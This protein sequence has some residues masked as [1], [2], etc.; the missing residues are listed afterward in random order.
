MSDA[1]HETHRWGE[2]RGVPFCRDCKVEGYEDEPGAF[3]ECPGP[4]P[5]GGVACGHK[6]ESLDD[7]GH[8]H[9]C[10]IG[11]HPASMHFCDE[12]ERWFG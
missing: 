4:P 10:G 1:L 2:R 6:V 7:P 12:C 11:I 3:A 8:Q 5:K 9:E